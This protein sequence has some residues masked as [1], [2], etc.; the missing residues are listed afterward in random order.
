[1]ANAAMTMPVV[2]K[3]SSKDFG[4]SDRF[5]TAYLLGIDPWSAPPPL[6][7]SSLSRTGMAG[8]LEGTAGLGEMGPVEGAVGGAVVGRAG[9]AGDAADA[10]AAAVRVGAG[11]GRV[12]SGARVANP[13]AGTCTTA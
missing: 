1:M 4:G 3:R 8:V 13:L 9:A 12:T 2:P 7:M 11:A 6:G 5:S 10:V